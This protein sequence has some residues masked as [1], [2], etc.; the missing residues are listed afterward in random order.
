MKKIIKK[1]ISICISASMM[2]TLAATT[3]SAETND[4]SPSVEFVDSI[5]YNEPSVYNDHLN[6]NMR[7][8]S[9]PTA[10]HDLSEYDYW[11]TLDEVK[12]HWLYTNYYFKPNDDSEIYVQYT[13][14]S[15]TGRPTQMKIGMYDL[16]TEK[17]VVTWT[18]KESTLDGVTG[19]VRF[20]NL[21]KDHRYAVAFTAVY[22]GMSHDSVHGNA[23]VSHKSFS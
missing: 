1:V 15:D 12:L 21:N 16:D 22:D 10:F 2:V 23:E 8:L 5:T 6:G 20:Y 3:V 19:S 18:S 9:L 7:S 14:Y 4:L 13:I 11:A 17:M